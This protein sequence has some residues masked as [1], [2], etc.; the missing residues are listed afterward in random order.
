MALMT[1]DTTKNIK[2]FKDIIP[3]LLAVVFVA[4]MIYVV[5]IKKPAENNLYAGVGALESA[6]VLDFDCSCEKTFDEPIDINW[7]GNVI[8][9]MVSGEA[10]GIRKVPPDQENPLF[11]ACC[12]DSNHQWLSGQVRVEGKWTGITC[13]YKNSIF[14]RCVPEVDIEKIEAVEVSEDLDF[15][16]IQS[17]YNAYQAP[18][19]VH[20]RKALNGYLSGT[21]EGMDSEFVIKK[22]ESESYLAGLDSFDKAYY[23]SKF[24][25]L[26]ITRN[27]YGGELITI[28]F[29]DKPDKIFRAW[30]YFYWNA[31]T[32]DYYDFRDF[33]QMSVPDDFVAE[34]VAQPQIKA[35]LQDEEHSI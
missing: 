34:L 12:G 8:S 6:S 25:V 31:G 4:S 9:H 2:N 17:Y 24:I 11:Y 20:L 3:Q 30:V 19:V 32:P 28:I 26:D 14:G 5:A 27:D 1:G 10:Y 22:R 35:A 23:K 15:Q 7:S 29:R 33:W 16:D 18:S 13:G 21:N